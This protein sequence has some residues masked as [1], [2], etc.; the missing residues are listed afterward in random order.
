MIWRE[1][2]H[3]V[4]YFGLIFKIKNYINY[5]IFGDLDLHP[6]LLTGCSQNLDLDYF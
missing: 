2:R 3:I 4:V 6:D 5:F 1:G